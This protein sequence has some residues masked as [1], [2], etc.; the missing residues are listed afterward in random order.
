MEC[1]KFDGNFNLIKEFLHL[2][3][4]EEVFNSERHNLIEYLAF[5]FIVVLY[6]CEI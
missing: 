5:T 1:D 3:E 6:S 4:I 2:K